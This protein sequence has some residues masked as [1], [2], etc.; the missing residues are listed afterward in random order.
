MLCVIKPNFSCIEVYDS[1][2]MN[3]MT[4]RTG[5]VPAEVDVIILD[6]A[7][8]TVWF[9]DVPT[10]KIFRLDTDTDQ[11]EYTHLKIAKEWQL[12]RTKDLA[13]YCIKCAVR[14]AAHLNGWDEEE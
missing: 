7:E 6:A 11:C 3:E 10:R 2:E 12:L 14:A 8:S 5:Y 13:R 1:L 9:A 4:G